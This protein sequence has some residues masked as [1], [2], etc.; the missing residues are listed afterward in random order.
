MILDDVLER[1]LAAA[2]E[3]YDV[4]TGGIDRLRDELAPRTQAQTRT[5]NPRPAGLR[6]LR[7]RG[8]RAAMVGL[9]AC[10]VLLVGVPIAVGG[11]HGGESGGANGGGGAATAATSPDAGRLAG[12]ASGSSTQ[13]RDSLA[14]PLAMPSPTPQEVGGTPSPVRA[15]DNRVVKTGELDLQVGKGKVTQTLQAITALATAEGGYVSDSQTQEAGVAPSGQVTL[16]VPVGRFEDTVQHARTIAGT[17][18]LSLRTSGVDVTSRYVDLQ[19]R[20]KALKATRATFLT[21]LSKATT[22]GQ[23]LA[24]QQQVTDVQTQ[25]EQLQGQLK[26]LADS[27]AMS[28]LT[29]T[30]DQK[31]MAVTPS[32]PH[33]D[34][35]FVK[36]VKLS[37]SRFVRGVEAIVGVIGPI[38]LALLLVVLGWLAARFGYRATRR[39]LV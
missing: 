35:G 16:R 39:H 33:H 5:P 24:V 18:V 34:N 38:V 15:P 19:A 21:I 37:V 30:V 28:T 2:A 26:V 31:A 11:G 27:S 23:T 29:V 6:R 4:P 7:P 8:P 20:I 12:R 32:G 25:I 3:E 22:I 13:T 9:A 1:G 17:K 10:L 14:L 36:A